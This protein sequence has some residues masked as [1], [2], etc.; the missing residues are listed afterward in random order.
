MMTLSTIA[1]ISI[2]LAVC[3]CGADDGEKMQ[4]DPNCPTDCGEWCADPGGCPNPGCRCAA[5]VAE[6]ACGEVTCDPSEVCVSCNCGGPTSV[7]CQPAPSECAADRT[8]ACLEDHLCP[9]VS[10]SCID[11]AQNQILCESE[12]D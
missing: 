7:E 12:L 1:R 4:M 10:T 5:P 6:T 11:Q 9:D 8:C 2:V 3:A